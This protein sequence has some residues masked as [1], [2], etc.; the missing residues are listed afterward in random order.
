MADT[1]PDYSPGDATHIAPAL[2]HDAAS[3]NAVTVQESPHLS[4]ALRRLPHHRGCQAMTRRRRPH[5]LQPT[6]ARSA[7]AI[8]LGTLR[9]LRCPSP[10]RGPCAGMH[11]IL[12]V[13]PTSLPMSGTCGA[14]RSVQ[15]GRPKPLRC[16]QAPAAHMPPRRA[17]PD[18]DTTSQQYHQAVPPPPSYPP[19]V[20]SE[21]V[22]G[23]LRQR[24]VGCCL[25]RVARTGICIGHPCTRR[26]PALDT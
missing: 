19:V 20:L 9:A 4:T 15:R 10:G 5:V 18:H 16:S 7:C 21:V 3:I 1:P 8:S 25:A 17:R 2:R 22:P 26:N 23:G 12:G 24:C 14:P 13:W 6:H 11:C